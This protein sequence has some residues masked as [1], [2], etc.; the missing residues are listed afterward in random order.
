MPVISN[1]GN[2]EKVSEYLDHIL[3]LAMQGSWSC[4]KYSGDFLKKVKHVRQIS[5]GAILVTTVVVGFYPSITDKDGLKILRRRLNER[6]TSEIPTE[7]IVQWLYFLKI[8][9]LILMG[10]L[11]DK[12]QVQQVVPNLY[13]LT[14]VF[15]WMK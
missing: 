10:R 6:Q 8:I 9:F 14:L 2:K 5:D 3:K 13:L 11:K 7:D 12:N 15:S 1:C 4:I